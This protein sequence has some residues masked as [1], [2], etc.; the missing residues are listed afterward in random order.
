MNII[1]FVLRSYKLLLPDDERNSDTT[2]GSEV[3]TGIAVKEGVEDLMSK[4]IG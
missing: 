2:D 4:V 3:E 1:C